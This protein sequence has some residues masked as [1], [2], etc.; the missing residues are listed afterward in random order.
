MNKT[1]YTDSPPCRSRIKCEKCRA[2]PVYRAT[3]LNLYTLPADAETRRGHWF[4]C[5]HGIGPD[6]DPSAQTETPK[7]PR[8]KRRPPVNETEAQRAAREKRQ[9]ERLAHFEQKRLD[10]LTDAERVRLAARMVICEPCPAYRRAHAD[11]VTC[12]LCG[13]GGA[14][15]SRVGFR[16]PDGR[17]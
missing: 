3:L 8:H 12:N 14:R 2:D 1:P 17:F 7:R 6:T 11:T 15:I 13:C 5:P 16:C 10:A 9:A 4:K